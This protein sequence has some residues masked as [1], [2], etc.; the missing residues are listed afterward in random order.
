MAPISAANKASKKLE[1]PSS[2]PQLKNIAQDW[3][4]YQ[5]NRGIAS[6]IS[7]KA[8]EK[9]NGASINLKMLAEDKEPAN[10]SY[11]CLQMK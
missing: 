11:M 1:F 6:N 8:S 3:G 5:E 7:D 9:Y 4:F 2:D 10:I